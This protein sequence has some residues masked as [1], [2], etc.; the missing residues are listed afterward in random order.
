[1][2]CGRALHHYSS[3]MIR[4]EM[5]SQ[6]RYFTNWQL[7]ARNFMKI[8]ISKLKLLIPRELDM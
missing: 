5:S 4:A 7:D 1:M 6:Y 2:T 3:E 8:A